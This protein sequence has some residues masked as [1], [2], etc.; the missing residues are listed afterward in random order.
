MKRFPTVPGSMLSTSSGTLEGSTA[1]VSV[2]ERAGALGWAA[3][4]SMVER[5]AADRGSLFM[6]MKVL[7][8]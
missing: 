5:I 1:L 4:L 2:F 3:G 7:L 8:Y 6:R